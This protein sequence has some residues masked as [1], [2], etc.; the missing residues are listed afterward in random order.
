[1]SVAQPEQLG[2]SADEAR[3]RLLARGPVQAPATSRS[4][5]SIV[6]A[7]VFTIFNLILRRRGVLTLAFGDWQDA[8]FLAI[9]V[10][11]A[12][13]GIGQEIRAKLTL[14]RLAALVAPTAT[15]VRDGSPRH[16]EVDSVVEGDVVLL[17]P[18]DQVVADG[19]LVE[20]GGL[21]LDESILTG[22]A[23][24]VGRATG[25]EVRSGSFAVEGGGAY[26]V[27]AVGEES[28]AA[29]V[30]G[31]ARAIPAHAVTAR[32]RDQ[33]PASRARRRAGPARRCARV[34]ALP[35]TTRRSTTRCRQRSPP[36]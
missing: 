12:A 8:I 31:E 25:E 16:L 11:N 32:A 23:E 30:A 9:L 28:Y 27:T 24:P 1:M 29:R 26:V 10:A 20:S 34:G 5:K 36:S 19:T 13:I 2:L 33:P 7:N 22:E 14:D 17:E 18:G 4:Y 21:A 35:P 3:R 6:V 15:V